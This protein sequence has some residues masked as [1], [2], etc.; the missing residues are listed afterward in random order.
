MNIEQQQQIGR[1]E[2]KS[3][4]SGDQFWA[5]IARGGGGVANAIKLCSA[6]ICSSEGNAMRPECSNVRKSIDDSAPFPSV[7]ITS[8]YYG[9]NEI[10]VD[11]PSRR[12]HRRSRSDECSRA[13]VEKCSVSRGRREILA[14]ILFRSV[15]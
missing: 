11:V 1:R 5:A 6:A 14:Y 9:A 3:I 8:T 2:L 15:W 13:F 7:K 4:D 12:Y 10:K